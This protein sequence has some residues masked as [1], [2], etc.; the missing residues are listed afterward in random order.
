[1]PEAFLEPP[2]AS[3]SQPCA[4]IHLKK[5]LC[6]TRPSGGTFIKYC[7]AKLCFMQRLFSRL[8]GIHVEWLISL[9]LAPEAPLFRRML[10][11]SKAFLEP[12]DMSWPQ[13]C[14]RTHLKKG[15]VP[16]LSVLCD[17]C[18][19]SLS[20]PLLCE[21]ACQQT[22][23]FLCQTVNFLEPQRAIPPAFNPL[24]KGLGLLPGA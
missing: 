22:V 17:V 1:M 13:P 24:L 19:I 15:L 11:G 2:D 9:S 20:Q 12:P 8:S 7:L 14:T 3:G 5:T 23:W 10:T 16:H 4:R 6:H 21:E 18:Q